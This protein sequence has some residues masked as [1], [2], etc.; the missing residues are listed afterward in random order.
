MRKESAKIM[1]GIREKK[2]KEKKSLTLPVKT[3][4]NVGPPYPYG[5]LKSP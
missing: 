1:E 5:C 4:E 3:L 2:R